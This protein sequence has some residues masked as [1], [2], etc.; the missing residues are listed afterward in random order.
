[1]KQ[2]TLN[3]EQLEKELESPK[4]PH[5][6]CLIINEVGV[7]LIEEGRKEA[8]IILRKLLN[9]DLDG[10]RL[11]AF[12]YLSVANDSDKETQDKLEEFRKEETN[13]HI[14]EDARDKIKE[15]KEGPEFAQNPN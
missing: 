7:L 9:S 15:F 4:R 8:E 1:M 13:K 11:L 14:I 3:L 6:R 5:Q 10:D 2:T 12:C